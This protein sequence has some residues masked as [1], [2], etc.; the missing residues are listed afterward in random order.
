[1]KLTHLD[2][3]VATG[4]TPHGGAHDGVVATDTRT[5]PDGCWFLALVG[6]RFD[7]HDFAAKAAAAG[8][9]I[10]SRP[11]E[12]WDRPWVAVDDTTVALQDLGRWAR[13]RLDGPVVALTGSS[14]KTT[15]RALVACALSPMGHVHQTGG[16]LN[17]HLGVPMTLLA[18]PPDAAAHVVEMGTSSPGEI[19][20]LAE[21][22]RPDVRLVL[23]VGPAHLEELG[24]LEG[25]AVE[26]GAMYDTAGADDVCIVNLDDPFLRDRRPTARTITWG[27]DE[28]AD[29]RLLDVAVDA[30][31]WSTS[32]RYAT[33]GGL[34]RATI[35]APGV[36]IAH[37]AGAALAIAYALGV[38]LADAAHALSDYAPVGMRLRP[39]GLP[40]GVLAIN[41]A[42]N[43]NPASVNAS[44]DTLAAMDGRRVAVL[45][46]MLEL[47]PD[48][49]ALH[50]EVAQGAV[51]RG[52]DLVVL[53]G[54]RMAATGVSG[55]AVWRAEDGTTLASDLA[56]WLRRGD[57]VLFKGSRGARVERVLDAVRAALEETR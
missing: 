30:T 57:R 33:P 15:T 44:L 1:M 27:R 38:D 53:V 17:N 37:D 23:N 52:L 55:D 14:G 16:N 47:G 12:G 10:F 35:P 43:A 19:R 13:D 40:G 41:D 29:I 25:V 54:P 7:G 28:A 8:G 48:E 22:A 46:D 56:A 4:G 42:Y 36:H 39:E 31:T 2:I 34:V 5:L 20:F 11:V 3:A 24:G 50:V 21:L 6:D 18:A 49:A 26:K 45:G 9:G 51:A 32:A